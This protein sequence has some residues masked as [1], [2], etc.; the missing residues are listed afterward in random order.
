MAD[1]LPSVELIEF[2]RPYNNDVNLYITNISRRLD[3]ET[4]Q[5]KLQQI[6]SQ[7]GLLYEVQVFN[8]SDNSEGTRIVGLINHRSIY[9]FIKFFSAK[10]AK[11]AKESISGKRLLD[12]QFLKVQ[13]AQR[14]KIAEAGQLPLYMA[15]CTELANY[16][17]GFNGWT[18]KIVQVEKLKTEECT[19]SKT[20]NINSAI[21]KCVVSLEIKGC[22]F[23]CYGTGYGGDYG[24]LQQER[25]SSRQL[26][27]LG[28]AKKL[29][30]R[31]AYENAFKRVIIVCLDNGKVAVEINQQDISQW[32][33]DELSEDGIVQVNYMEEMPH[34]ES[35]DEREGQ[36]ECFSDRV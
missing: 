21:F 24:V 10:A 15:K 12:G 19:D 5:L 7:Y 6:F 29:A 35:D 14:K 23:I 22:D 28:F 17:F 4:V 36:N 11:R 30:H 3:K 2:I 26:E 1:Y 9:A 20:D 18:T 32:S 33:L 13:F 8:T 27:L 16:Y 31:H 25:N 34:S